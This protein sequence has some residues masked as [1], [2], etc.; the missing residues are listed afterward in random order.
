[1]KES[2]TAKLNQMAEGRYQPAARAILS[3][4]LAEEC[5]IIESMLLAATL[6]PVKVRHGMVLADYFRP[7]YPP[8]VNQYVIR[9]LVR[10]THDHTIGTLSEAHRVL[11]DHPDQALYGLNL[12]RASQL[13]HAMRDGA[14]R[15]QHGEDLQRWM[16]T[17]NDLVDVELECTH[18]FPAGFD[19]LNPTPIAR[20]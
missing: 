17:H 9:E 12:V 20:A 1:M 11:R 4:E 18:I 6:L 15:F 19:L 16:C 3:V 10:C 13:L 14:Y 2:I 7:A 8:P 5:R